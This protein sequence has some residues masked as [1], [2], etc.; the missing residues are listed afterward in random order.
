M[1]PPE[2]PDEVRDWPDDPFSLLGVERGADDLTVRRA[3]TRLIRRF[4]PEL[5]PEQFSRIRNAYEAC[6]RQASWFFAEQLATDSEQQAEPRAR[7]PEVRTDPNGLEQLWREAIGG[8][9]PHAYDGLVGLAAN[10]FEA[11]EVSLRLYWLLAVEPTLD[12]VRTRHDW[13]LQALTH[14]QLSGP[15]VELYRRELQA[16]PEAGLGGPY[17]DLLAI[18]GHVYQL[19]NLAQ[20]RVVAAIRLDRHDLIESDLNQLKPRIGGDD[21]PAWLAFLVN[22]IEWSVWSQSTTVFDFCMRELDALKH[23]ELRC[24]YQ[25]DRIDASLYIGT[26]VL[27]RSK[28]MLSRFVRLL[29]LTVANPDGASRAEVRS[30]LSEVAKRPHDYLE[31]F[32]DLF[33]VNRSNLGRVIWGLLQRYDRPLTSKLP[34]DVLRT[35]V[36]QVL[37]IAYHKSKLRTFNVI[38][39]DGTPWQEL[40]SVLLDFLV[41]DHIDP[42]DLASACVEDDE[43]PIRH[44]GEILRN[45]VNLRIVWLACELSPCEQSVRRIQTRIGIAG[46]GG[47][48]NTSR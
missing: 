28:Q 12:V 39:N 4:K 47:A 45:D 16:D 14:T 13:L 25:F 41:R 43:M 10:R 1:P 46:F 40:S 8:N 5:Y 27:D 35:Y 2:L 11:T 33:R 22:T 44:I 20:M 21:D 19:L 15:A 32:D 42:E 3:Y 26:E 38:S 6:Q 24:G 34:D 7:P 29:V 30:G 9:R 18:P 17:R 36:R 37:E 48:R 23:L 31:T